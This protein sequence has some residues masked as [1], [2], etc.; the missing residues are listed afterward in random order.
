MVWTVNVSSFTFGILAG[1]VITALIYGLI[2][3]RKDLFGI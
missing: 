3:H 1:V 2:K